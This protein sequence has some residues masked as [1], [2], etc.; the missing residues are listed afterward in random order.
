MSAI[1]QRNITVGAS[2]FIAGFGTVAGRRSLGAEEDGMKSHIRTWTI[3]AAAV[4]TLSASIAAQDSPSQAPKPKHQKYKLIDLGTF[5]GPASYITSVNGTGVGS[6]FLNN[7][8]IV[9]GS[10]DTPIPDPYAPNCS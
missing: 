8:G 10:A 2:T 1:F 3:A 6:R 7:Q 9:T 5:G 4:L